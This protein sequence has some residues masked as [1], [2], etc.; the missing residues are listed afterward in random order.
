MTETILKHNKTTWLLT[1]LLLSL[2]LSS[3][4]DDPIGSGVGDEDVPEFESIFPE[5]EVMTYVEAAHLE[6]Q[7]IQERATRN[8]KGFQE[9][10]PSYFFF[11][12]FLFLILPYLC[13]LL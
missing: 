13:L 3:P 4:I 8:I 9:Q 11:L 5:P 1:L 6:H 7:R 12:S 10:V 2:S